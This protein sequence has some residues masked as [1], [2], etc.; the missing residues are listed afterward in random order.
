MNITCK[1]CDKTIANYDTALNHLEIDESHAAD[2]CQECIDKFVKW[3]QGI[4]ACLF[5]TSAMKRMRKKL[6]K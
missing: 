1:L 4:Y 6:E 3:Q 5:P 2:I